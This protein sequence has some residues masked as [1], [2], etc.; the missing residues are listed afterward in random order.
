MRAQPPRFPITAAQIE[1][2]VTKFY[3]Q[4][5]SD[6]I[7]GPVFAAH[8][9]KDG[10]PA[11]EAKIAS[12]WRNAILSERSYDGNPMQ[13]HMNA[14]D[15]HAE[16]FPLWLA[17]FDKVLADELPQDTASAFSNLAHRIARGLRMG[18]EDLRAPLDAPPI[19]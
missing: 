15:V 17:L 1:S 5:R 18:V 16:H 19:L 9:P 13:K 14:R 11:H 6:T 12:F 7:L 10:W 2:V 4:V 8:I 3:A